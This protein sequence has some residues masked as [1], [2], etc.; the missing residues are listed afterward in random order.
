[1]MLSRYF[2]L[3]EMTTSNYALRHGLDNT[4]DKAMVLK[5]TDT[6]KKMDKVRSLLGV[7]V[8]V[9]SGYR[10][11]LVNMGVGSKSTSQHLKGEAVDFKTHKYN[12]R[13]IVQ[14]IIDS[15]IEFD[16]LILEYDAWV[17]ISFKYL[18]KDNRKQVLIIDKKGTRSF[19]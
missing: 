7:P 14:K 10:S 2:S 8:I 12:P 4:P 6:A 17:H 19:K 1:M 13:E 5:L 9:L 11:A 16:Q 3:S 15:E 18:A